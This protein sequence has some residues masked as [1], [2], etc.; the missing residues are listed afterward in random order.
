MPALIS[1]VC[2]MFGIGLLGVFGFFVSPLSQEFDVGVASI[3][4]APVFLLLAPALVGPIIGRF[5]DTH[6]IRNIILCGV[7]LS[8]VALYGVSHAATLVVAGGAF[9]LYAV[10]STLYGPLVLNSLVI[11]SYRDKVATA[12][13]IGAM[14][15]SAGTVLI[16]YLVAGLMDHFDWRETLQILATGMGAV[17]FLCAA[18][19]LP[20]NIRQP[21]ETPNIIDGEYVDKGFLATPAFWIIG[22][23][24]A[25]I[26]NMALMLSVC[27][28]PHFGQQG[29]SNRA[30]ATFL[31]AGGAAGFC[32]KL[33]VASFVDRWRQYLKTISIGVVLLALAG[34]STLL[35]GDSFTSNA[36]G[37][38]LLGGSG[39]AFLP[40]YPYL[41]SRYFDSRTIGK[42]NGA[43]APLMLP[44]GLVSAPLAGY[45]FDVRGSYQLAFVGALVLLA[46]AALLLTMLPAS[47]E[48]VPGQQAAASAD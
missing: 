36:F 48:G 12:L 3:N 21:G 35:L 10:G 47:G 5:L 6:S 37:V 31:A 45:A 42:V 29:F 17:L 7:L 15:V 24:L 1:A 26:F 20:R 11:K 33:L 28:A 27:Y 4:I 2:Q 8:M 34:V 43:Q 13:A 23:A 44:L 38:A 30:I 41:N 18:L 19:G 32:A 16:P 9:F 39:G 22:I 14:G 46:F 40:L 25:V